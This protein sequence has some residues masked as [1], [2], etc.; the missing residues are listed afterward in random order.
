MAHDNDRGDEEQLESLQGDAKSRRSFLIGLGKWSA[1]A[2][3]VAL[4]DEAVDSNDEVLAQRRGSWVNRRGRGGWLNRSRGGGGWLNRG[5]Y[6]GWVNWINNGGY[7]V[8]RTWINRRAGG[9][10]INRRR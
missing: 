4:L 10:W 6:Y 2:I 7:W 8:N 3:S 5:G 1:V 9:G